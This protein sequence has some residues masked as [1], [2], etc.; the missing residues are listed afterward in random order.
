MKL[1]MQVVKRYIIISRVLLFSSIHKSDYEIFIQAAKGYIII[2]P[3]TAQ[4]GTLES[5][6]NNPII[7]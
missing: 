5:W 4:D 3:M 1:F 7:N 2:G 6:T